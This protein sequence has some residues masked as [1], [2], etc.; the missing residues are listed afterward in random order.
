MAGAFKGVIRR[1]DTGRYYLGAGKWGTELARAARF[2]T[3]IEVLAE[4]ERYGMR[5]CCE[6][7]VALA[8]RS[9]LSISFPL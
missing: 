3:L 2:Q 8:G 4:T 6:L 9:G 5:D 1:R 7:L